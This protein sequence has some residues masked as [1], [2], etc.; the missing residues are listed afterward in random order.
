[1]VGNSRLPSKDNY[2]IGEKHEMFQIYKCSYCPIEY[3]VAVLV[4]I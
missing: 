2:I 3:I 4:R 1:M